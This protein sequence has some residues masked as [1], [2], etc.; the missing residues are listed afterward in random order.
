VAPLTAAILAGIDQAEAGIGSAINNAVARVAGLIA[1]VAIGAIVA[2]QF[3]S[4]LDRHL[5]GQPLTPRGQAAVTEA[6][7][8]TLGRPSVAGVPPREAV[9]IT[10]A[11]ADSSLTAFRVGIGVASALVVIG[12]LIGA[13]GIRNP[14]RV[15]K[16]E[17]CPGGQLAGS[18]LDAAGLHASSAA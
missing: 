8:L 12:G 10:V 7:Q 4:S 9:A 14:R 15:V 6:K 5:A 16:A 3:S 17:Q 13:V 2:A 18:P 11:S 1:T